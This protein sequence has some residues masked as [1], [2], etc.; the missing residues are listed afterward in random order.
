MSCSNEKA[1][2]T[3]PICN[4]SKHEIKFSGHSGAPEATPCSN[5]NGTGE[6]PVNEE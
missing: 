6:H 5:C 1:K 3:C 2:G 4:G